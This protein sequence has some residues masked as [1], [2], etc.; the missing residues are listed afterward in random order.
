MKTVTICSSANF[1]RQAVDIQAQLEKLGYRAIIPVI[2]EKMKISSDYDVSNVKPWLSNNKDY[3]KKTPLI[4]SHFKE[5]A[6]AD[7]ILVLNFEKHGVSNY[8][9]GNVL[10][11]MAIAFYL[12]KPIFILNEIPEESTFL[13]KIRALAP[14]VLHGKLE[15][16]KFK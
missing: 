2:A 14:V 4:R 3:H 9:G 16:L 1:Y 11:E 10:M 15:K 12:V 7:G 8:I 5:V 6:K 13:E